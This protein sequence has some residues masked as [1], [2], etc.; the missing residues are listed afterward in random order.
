[1]I[2]LATLEHLPAINSIY[3]QAVEDGLR[4]AHIKPLSLNERKLWFY[5]H[6]EDQYPIFVYIQENQILGWISIS[7]YRADRQALDEVVEVSYYVH[8]DHHGEGIGSLLMQHAVDFCET[9]HYRTMI[10]ILVSDNRPSIALLKKYDFREGGRIPKAIH[11]K[12]EFR[13][14]IYMYKIL[15][16]HFV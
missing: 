4:T 1:M 8:Y 10:A 7:A 3:N 15:S 13:D 11:Y 9:A 6:S 12:T 2:T 16:S 14:H 5:E